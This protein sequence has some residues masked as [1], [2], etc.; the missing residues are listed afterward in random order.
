MHAELLRL[1]LVRTLMVPSPGAGQELNAQVPGGV[2]WEILE[3][4]YTFATSAV[5]G[6]REPAL[7]FANADGIHVFRSTIGGTQAAS[8]TQRYNYAAGIGGPVIATNGVGMLPNPPLVMMPESLIASSTVNLDA[9]DVYS[10]IALTVREW[11]PEAIRTQAEW[12]A[13]RV[14]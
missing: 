14:R 13:K 8:L 3:L 1:R 11:T 12:I 2:V 4:A 10:A 7:R 9:G 5:V 6:G